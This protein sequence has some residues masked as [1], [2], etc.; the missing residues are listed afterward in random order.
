LSKKLIA[1]LSEPYH[2]DDEVVHISASIG[3]TI[4]PDDATSIEALVKNADQAMYVSKNRGRNR[5]SH[6]TQ[7]LQDAAQKKLRISTDLRSAITNEEFSVYFQPI[8]DLDS[9]AIVKAE[10]LLRWNHPVIGMVNP[11]DFIPVAE[12]IGIISEIGDWVFCEVQK[13]QEDW[14]NKGH[15]D[16]S[17]SVNMSPVQFKVPVREFG[18]NWLNRSNQRSL[19]VEIT[20]GLLLNSEPETL[21]KLYLLR[22]AGI[23]VSIDDF[24]TGYSSLSYLKEFDIDYL[25]IDQSFVR[26]LEND[27]NDVALSEAIIAMAHKLGLKV[28]AEGVEN[29]VQHKILAA[30]GCDFAQGY[31]YSMPL[32]APEFESLVNTFLF[33][34]AV[35]SECV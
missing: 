16:I 5:F 13:V 2:L 34:S 19:S 26:N 3:I 10:A 12:D 30:A 18:K 24:G 11:R 14:R 25:K 20:E 35:V 27:L 9:N 33:S 1:R 21:K 4:F 22:D 17:V 6:F 15:A 31:L 32:P 23:E 7:S 8:I 28:I 29:V